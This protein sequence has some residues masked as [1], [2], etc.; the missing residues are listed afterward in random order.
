M[1]GI[2]VGKTTLAATHVDPLT[3]AVCWALTVPNTSIGIARLLAKTPAGTPWVVEPTGRY[4]QTV[5]VH[6]A[7]RDQVVLLAQPKRA[8]AFLAALSPRAKTDRLDSL[9]LARYGLAVSLRPY[10]IKPPLMDQLDQLLVARTGIARAVAQ[11]RQQQDALPEAAAHLATA[12]AGLQTQRTALDAAI[13]LRAA[14]LPAVAQLD[15]VPGIGP[16]IAAALAS[17]LTAK[18][19]PTPDSFVAYIGLDPRVHDSGAHRGQRALSKQG[20]AELRRLLYLA[21]QANLRVVAS[22]FREQYDRER[23]KGLS[24]TAALN[25]VARKLARVC[26]S[27]VRHHASYDPNLVYQQRSLTAPSEILP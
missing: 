21:A 20:N 10:P 15:R 27:L 3:G 19:F 26:W 11:L 13:A 8:K 7:A 5:A 22:P 2:D 9:G 4:S 18:A 24:I 12:V 1:I 17:C 6:A 16:V 23:A 25:A 14:D